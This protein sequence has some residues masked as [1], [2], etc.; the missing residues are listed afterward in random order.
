MKGWIL[1][2]KQQDELSQEDYDIHRLL[3]A[4]KAKHIPLKIYSPKEFELIVSRDDQKSVLLNGKMIALPDF[5]IPRIGAKTTYFGLAVIRQLERLNIYVCNMSSTVEIVKDKLRIHQILA[6]S[7]LP[8]P[9]TMLLK[10]PVNIELVEEEINFPLIIKDINGTEG[11]GIYLCESS[12][13]FK[14]L[15]ELLDSYKENIHMIIQEFISGS[16]G[17]DLRVIVIGG[18]VIGCIKRTATDGSFKANYSLGAKI[19]PFQLNPEIESL[20]LETAKLLNLE[21][22]G[23]DLLF[24]EEGYKVLEANSSPG[25]EGFEKV[26]GKYVAEE[27]LSHVLL[28][29]SECIKKRG[30]QCVDL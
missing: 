20:A 22:A 10:F 18:K 28:Q 21:T 3:E 8:T 12:L 6:E 16:K 23:I 27:I 19:E 25:F 7:N 11:Q 17:T 5:L 9:K 1:Y 2:H 24:N 14:E 30:N 13:K 4:A 26:N 29:T 15:M